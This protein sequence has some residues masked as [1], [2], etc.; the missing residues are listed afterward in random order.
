[1]L[2]I[3]GW[4]GCAMLAVK[5]MEMCFDKSL[6]NEDGTRP[7]PL[8]YTIITGFAATFGFAFWILIQGY[9]AE[10]P[11]VDELSQYEQSADEAERIARCIEDAPNLE[12]AMNCYED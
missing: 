7:D 9:S 4:L 3:V 5:L 6:L 8:F 2:Q 11:V 1:M 12:I 10:G